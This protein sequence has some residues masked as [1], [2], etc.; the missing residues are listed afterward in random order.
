MGKSLF[1]TA[2]ASLLF[3]AVLLGGYSCS[4][5]ED[6]LD[7]FE[8]KRMIEE[9]LRENNQKLEFTQW[10]IV[11]IT[12]KKDDW[13]WNDEEN[14]KRY[15]AVY[16]LPE[17]TEF[18]YEKGAVLG[19]VFIGEQDR[20]E[21]QKLLPYVHT[22]DDADPPYTE[23]IS[24]DIQYKNKGAV[25]PTVAFYIQASDLVQADDYLY[26]YNFRIVLIW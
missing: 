18:I 11:N 10:K 21:V 14:V 1:K 3:A 23:T 7:E 12:V 17:L 20:D 13:T 9:A 26:D 19:Y 2:M 5:S 6:Y 22:Y 24:F 16:N 4:R 15:E 8:V 25:K